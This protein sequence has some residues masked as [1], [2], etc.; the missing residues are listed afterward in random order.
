MIRLIART[1]VTVNIFFVA[2]Y[3]VYFFVKL[4]SCISWMSSIVGYTAMH[5]VMT[6]EVIR[7]LYIY[8][9]KDPDAQ[10]QILQV[11]PLSWPS[12]PSQSKSLLSPAVAVRWSAWI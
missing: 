12:N 3:V 11:I 5:I 7:M 8:M 6:V 1:R 10:D 9:P 4:G 2:S